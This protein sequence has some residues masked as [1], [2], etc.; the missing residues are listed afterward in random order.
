VE[1][2]IVLRRPA[3]GQH[4]LAFQ[5]RL[6]V[7][8]GP[9]NDVVIPNPHV[10]WTHAVLWRE[11]ECAFVQD[12]GTRNGTFLDERPVTDRA[13]WGVGSTL[14]IGD[15]EMVLELDEHGRAVTDRRM[16][17]VEDLETGVR[18]PLRRSHF[19][20]G[21]GPDASLRV[22]DTERTVLISRPSGEVWLAVGTEDRMLQEGEIFTVGWMRL[23]L[24]D[25]GDGW[26]PTASDGE[27]AHPY[28]VEAALLGA[29]GPRAR[30]ADAEEGTE[31]VVTAPN[32]VSLLYFLA[33]A[34]KQD[35]E[36]LVL[37][38][39]RGWRTNEAAA[40]AV[41]GR[42]ARMEDPRKLKT[43]IHNLRAELR[44]GGLD[45]W[46]LEKRRGA[47]RLRVIRTALS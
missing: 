35:R 29:A 3:G 5:Q 26:M 34:V 47:V 1:L 19:V 38:L 16:M 37:P 15:A 2:A 24:V 42:S 4:T 14:R 23:R 17:A 44:A 13:T 7:G 41:W 36:R 22:S 39:E 28:V 6:S 40:V 46:C 43:L 21:P 27:D 31:V 18:Y 10:S 11:G 25:S 30:I 12:L 9:E 20:L 32:R 8:R 33:E 45:P